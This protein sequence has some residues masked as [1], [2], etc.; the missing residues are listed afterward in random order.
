MRS[1]VEARFLDTILT[2]K[3]HPAIQS[4]HMHCENSVEKRKVK[5]T[6]SR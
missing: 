6:I 1:S 2:P 3:K 4:V 5:M